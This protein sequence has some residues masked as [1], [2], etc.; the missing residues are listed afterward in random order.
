MKVACDALRDLVSLYNV[1]NV[2]NTHGGVLLLEAYN[3]T[4]NNTPPWVFFT[5]FKIV[6]MVPNRAKHHVCYAKK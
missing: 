3:F 1:R 5:F 2:K 4:K 6:Q